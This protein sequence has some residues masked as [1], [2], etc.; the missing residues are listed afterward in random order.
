MPDIQSANVSGSVISQPKVTVD[1]ITRDPEVGVTTSLSA[2]P[3]LSYQDTVLSDAPIAYY[4]LGD[5]GP[6]A[7][8]VIAGRNGGSVSGPV[9]GVPG[10]LASDSDTAVSFSGT[11]YIAIPDDNVF[12]FTNGVNDLPFSI[13][14][15]INIPVLNVFNPIISKTTKVLANGNEWL[16]QV[17]ADGSI[18]LA[19]YTG[20]SANNHA[21]VS[22]PGVIIAGTKAHVVAT[23]AGSAST[24]IIYINGVPSP[25]VYVFNG[26]YTFMS[27]LGS[28]VEMGVRFRTEVTQEAFMQGVVD[29]VAIY[30]KV[31]TPTQIV[32]HFTAG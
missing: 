16:F 22:I 23:Y 20:T 32:T 12:S 8:D 31:L 28:A 15:W 14:A 30:D 7:V 17:S 3:V 6:T 18:L 10:L 2:L 25:M 26:T 19:L 24:A 27:N 29:E 21:G 5:V 11:S 1:I 9:F 4:R 13:E